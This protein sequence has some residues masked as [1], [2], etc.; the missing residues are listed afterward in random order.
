MSKMDEQIV[1]IE[2][3]KL[4]DGVYK[5]ELRFQG[6]ETDGEMIKRF[7][8]RISNNYTIMRRGDAEENTLFKQLIPYAVLKRGNEV[9]V[10]ERLSGGGETRL[11]NQLSIG[12]GGHANEFDGDNIYD[13]INENLQRELDEELDIEYSIQYK[14]PIKVIGL[15]N[16]DQ[17]DVGKVHIGVL[18]LINLPESTI[19]SV[20][21]VEQ[22]KGQWVAIEE[23]SNPDLFDRLE[24]WS[25]YA[26]DALR[27]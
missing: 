4:F 14:N 13:L 22:L 23:L 18:V 19:V 12:I 1:V 21:E 25:Q 11:H 6:T 9:F 2:C 16:D 17:Q 24:S 5:D 8:N 27:L 10:Y 15:V 26:L 3:S 7:M 20:R